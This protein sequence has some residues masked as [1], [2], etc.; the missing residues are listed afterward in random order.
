MKKILIICL[1]TMIVGC[2]KQP[3]KVNEW[4]KSLKEARQEDR[5]VLRYS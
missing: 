4:Q 3:E 1:A 2:Q 5:K